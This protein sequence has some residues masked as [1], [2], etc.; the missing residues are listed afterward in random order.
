MQGE[1]ARRDGW[2]VVQ[3][4]LA[5]RGAVLAEWVVQRVSTRQRAVVLQGEL[6]RRGGRVVVQH[7]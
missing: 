2:E 6:A 1:L 3:G 5:R 7:G 4:E